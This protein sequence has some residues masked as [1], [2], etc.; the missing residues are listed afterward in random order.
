MPLINGNF[1]CDDEKVSLAPDGGALGDTSQWRG[2]RLGCV[3]P[4]G[5]RVACVPIPGC[6]GVQES[7]PTVGPTLIHQWPRGRL[8]SRSIG[9]HVGIPSN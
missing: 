2:A 5:G 1:N 6:R 3:Q 8:H 4:P 7:L 9:G